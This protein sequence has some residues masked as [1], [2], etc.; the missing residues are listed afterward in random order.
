LL[1]GRVLDRLV[2]TLKAAG[3]AKGLYEAL[4]MSD[5]AQIREFYLFRIEGVDAELRTKFQKLY[6]YY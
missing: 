5:Q 6:Q 2:P 1:A 3:G 4:A